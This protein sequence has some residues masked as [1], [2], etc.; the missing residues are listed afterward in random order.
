MQFNRQGSWIL[1]R[2][3]V[4]DRGR[5]LAVFGDF[6]EARW[7]AAPLI[8]D[9]NSSG[10]LTFTPDCTRAEAERFVRGLNND[11]HKKERKENWPFRG[12]MNE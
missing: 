12:P 9:K 4:M 1:E 11:V 3:S 2:A 8:T 7:L 5:H 6:G 10:R